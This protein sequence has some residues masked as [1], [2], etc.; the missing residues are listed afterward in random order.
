[1]PKVQDVILAHKHDEL[2]V[3]R[4]EGLVAIDE[5]LYEPTREREL[6]VASFLTSCFFRV[7]SHTGLIQRQPKRWE[8]KFAHHIGPRGSNL[9]PETCSISPTPCFGFVLSNLNLLPKATIWRY[10]VKARF[11]AFRERKPKVWPDWPES[12]GL[13]RGDDRPSEVHRG[14]LLASVPTLPF[15]FIPAYETCCTSLASEG[16]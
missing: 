3:V 11:P 10:C 9:P 13:K 4:T 14:F 12:C 7:L 2:L 16:I 5:P 8:I 6:L 1:M 15:F